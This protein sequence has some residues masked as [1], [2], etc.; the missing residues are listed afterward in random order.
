MDSLTLLHQQARCATVV[1]RESLCGSRGGWMDVPK[2]ACLAFLGGGFAA[3]AA[4]RQ[5][6]LCVGKRA[7]TLG[8]GSRGGDPHQPLYPHAHA[9]LCKALKAH[10]L[11]ALVAM[12]L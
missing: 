5:L 3:A 4:M 8:T 10:K 7:K 12:G 6:W 1:L 2:G 11:E 9:C